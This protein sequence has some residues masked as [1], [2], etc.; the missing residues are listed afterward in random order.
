MLQNKRFCFA[1]VSF[2]FS[3][4]K[5]FLFMNTF[6]SLPESTRHTITLPDATPSA[7]LDLLDFG[8]AEEDEV[9]LPITT[10][11]YLKWFNEASTDAGIIAK[12]FHIGK[13]IDPKLDETLEGLGMRH[14]VVEHRT[15]DADGQT[16]K[17][18]WHLSPCSLIVVAEGLLSRR[19][20]QNSERRT[21]IAYGKEPVFDQQGQ[22]ERYEDGNPITRRTLKARVYLHELVKMGYQDWLPLTLHG[23]IID[24]FLSALTAQFRVLE[25]YRGY[26]GRKAPF[27]GFS[28]PLAP[29]AR[30]RLVGKG[31][32][33]SPIYPIV[34][35]LPST[36]DRAYLQAHLI[37]VWLIDLLR[38]SLLPETIVWSMEASKRIVSP[39]QQEQRTQAL[40]DTSHASAPVPSPVPPT[41]VMPMSAPSEQKEEHPTADRVIRQPELLW[42]VR[43]Y[44]QHDQ[45]LVQQ[46]CE[47]FRVPGLEQLRMSQ[48]DQLRLAHS[49]RKQAVR[50]SEPPFPAA[51][52]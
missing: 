33:Q 32:K 43:E 19:Q 36:I 5:E 35:Q 26:T 37:P 15:P 38:D 18:Y 51:S 52:R 2:L 31:A 28:L 8:L 30:R 50:A 14:Y 49:E 48:F 6:S 9:V 22:P 13:G 4:L 34:A 42:I 44:C 12:G 25:A 7:T 3:L 11:P 16:Q 1:S 45:Q 23:N 10:Q 21:G 17:P 39:R 46:L 27:Y 40:L 20:M 41:P 24:D 29:A 47:H